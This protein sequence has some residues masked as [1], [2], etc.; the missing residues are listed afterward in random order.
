MKKHGMVGLGEGAE[1]ALGPA[2]RCPRAPNA[3]RRS[4]PQRPRPRSTKCDPGGPLTIS[5]RK[6]EAGSRNH[7]LAGR[8]RKAARLGEHERSKVNLGTASFGALLSDHFVK[9]SL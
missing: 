3:G 2:V 8:T 9:W 4:S 5:E 6:T 1:N 7:Q